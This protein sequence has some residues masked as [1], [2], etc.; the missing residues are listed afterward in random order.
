[1]I[2]G[3]IKHP[4]SSTPGA[5]PTSAT[6]ATLLDTSTRAIEEGELLVNQADARLFMKTSP[7]GAVYELSRFAYGKNT[8]GTYLN[9][10]VV[11]ANFSTIVVSPGLYAFPYKPNFTYA[12][13]GVA[14]HVTG[15]GDGTA[16]IAVF[17]SDPANDFIIKQQPEFYQNGFSLAA[18]TTLDFTFPSSFV[19]SST[20]LYYLGIRFSS[21]VTAA[22]L[23]ALTPAS[24]PPNNMNFVSNTGG[25]FYKWDVGAAANQCEA[26]G[27][28]SG[29]WLNA[30]SWSHMVQILGNTPLI[31]PKIA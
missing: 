3:P 26:A 11:A 16:D 18:A 15:A 10:S 22:T 30:T 27:G 19:F 14:I 25:A 23:R 2:E 12:A 24:F 8:S 13:S 9:P 29:Q 17:E 21:A 28:T 4:S 20:K 7:N 6:V 31:A 5:T 1:M